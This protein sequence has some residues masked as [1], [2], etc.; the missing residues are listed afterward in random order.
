MVED[1]LE[2]G[3]GVQVLRLRL[4]GDADAMAQDVVADGLD[5]LRGDVAAA[6]EESVGLRGQGQVDRRPGAAAVLDV[7]R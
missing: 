6:F 3:L 7:L 1:P 4:V 5:V 2:D